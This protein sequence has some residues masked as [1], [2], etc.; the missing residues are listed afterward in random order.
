MTA[1]ILEQIKNNGFVN[2]YFRDISVA[3]GTI[4]MPTEAELKALTDSQFALAGQTPPSTLQVQNAY[5]QIVDA[6]NQIASMTSHTNRLSGI[7]LTGNG[8]LATIAKTMGAAKIINGENVC[9]T[10]IGAFGS[11]AKVNELVGDT[12]VAIQKIK[13]SVT[14]TV[15]NL[16]QN[17]SALT[18]F[19][20]KLSTQIASDGAAL[21]AGQLVVAQNAIASS[22]V[23]L[24][25]DE[26]LGDIFR[27]VM[28]QKLTEAVNVEKAKLREKI[29][30]ARYGY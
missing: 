10:V 20:T 27:N 1:S 4:S 13:D 11:L 29:H 18:A 3:Y 28:N 5:N 22:L 6:Y 14:D 17:T 8:T 26:C 2:P 21:V 15:N 25:D 7:D 23:D 19:A 24:I 9:S 30:V 16:L 12:Q